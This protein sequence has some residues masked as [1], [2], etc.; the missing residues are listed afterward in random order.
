LRSR[1]LVMVLLL[2]VLIG[3][4]A[5]QDRKWQIDNSHSAAQFA[6]KHLGISTVRGR[7]N[8]MSGTVQYDPADLSKTLIDVTIEA[9]S[10]DTRIETRDRDLRSPNWFD[11]EQFPTLTFKSKKVETA[12]AGRV[13]VAGDFTM[14][15]VTKE[16]VLDVD[17]PTTPLKDQRGIERVGTSAT[18]RINRRD[19]GVGGSSAAASDEV[20]ITIDLELMR[21]PATQ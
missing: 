15:G 16:V 7:F 17:P 18:T 20:M 4:A 11:V 9:N 14:K 5:A 8:K 21:P 10:I 2:A 6:V 13:R 12:G 19:F 1:Q 3:S